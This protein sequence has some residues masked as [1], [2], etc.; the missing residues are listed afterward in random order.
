VQLSFARGAV[1]SSRMT[2][3]ISSFFFL[4]LFLR[5]VKKRAYMITKFLVFKEDYV[6]WPAREGRPAAD[7][8]SLLL[9]DMTVPSAHRMGDMLT[10]R[11]SDAEREAWWGQ[12]EGRTLDIAVLG[13]YNGR[14]GKPF[15][16][17]KILSIPEKK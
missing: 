7:S 9:L 8:Y 3:E 6:H 4:L 5:V 13:I 10:Y 1:R 11:L 16:K 15:L 17:G 2:H 14:G 12:T